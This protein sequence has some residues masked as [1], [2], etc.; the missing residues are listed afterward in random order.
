MK[1]EFEKINYPSNLLKDKTIVISGA[2]S[3]I[4]RQIARSYAEFGADLILLSK[5]IEK[6]ES[7][8]EEINQ[9]TSSSVIIQPINFKTAD[10]KNYHE[11]VGAIKEEYSQIDGLVNNAGMTVVGTLDNNEED[12]W[13]NVIN[14][15]L[16]GPWALSKLWLKSRL[17][18]DQK[19][20]VILNVSSITGEAAQ[21][22]N[23]IY[24]ISKAALTHMTRQMALEWAKY[25]VR[26][27]AIA[28][29]YFRTDLN[30]EFL[31]SEMSAPMIKRVPL[32]RPGNIK[33]LEGPILLLASDAGSYM[34]GS[35]LV[36]DGG[37]L[38]RDL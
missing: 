12:D 9:I 30:S 7:I 5:S 18:K 17:E 28:P 4:G 25:N 36:V 21:K 32:R 35:I 31:D 14:T 2:G 15:N 26:V 8:Y 24:A 33:E 19:D 11:I 6:L 29:G 1:M 23:G 16:R 3:G 22:G 20:G 10:E 37:H 13:N 38:V 27:N 34:T